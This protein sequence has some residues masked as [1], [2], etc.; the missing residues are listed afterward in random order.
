[1]KNAAT[2]AG[3]GLLYTILVM[4]ATQ[5]PYTCALSPDRSR[6]LNLEHQVDRE[7][8]DRDARQIP[9]MARRYATRL[10]ASTRDNISDV[11]RAVYQCAETLTR[12]VMK[13]HD[14]T[15]EQMRVR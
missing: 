10:H 7:H 14:V 3:A 4:W 11:E 2:L 15:R 5:P 12:D 9:R 6:Q 13:T 1:M 8:L